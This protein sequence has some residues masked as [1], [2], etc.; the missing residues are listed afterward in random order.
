MTPLAEEIVR[1]AQSVL[2]SLKKSVCK[3]LFSA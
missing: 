2:E 3:D 1:E